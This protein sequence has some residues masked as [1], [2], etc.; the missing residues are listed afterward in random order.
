MR[1]ARGLSAEYSAAYSEIRHVPVRIING[2]EGS[3][4]RLELRIGG[5]TFN[6]NRGS[7]GRVGSTCHIA[8]RA[9]LLNRKPIRPLKVPGP[10]IHVIQLSSAH[11]QTKRML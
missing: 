6:G 1:V 7:L 5:T 4:R 2:D 9:N 3:T 8:V 10:L 11:L